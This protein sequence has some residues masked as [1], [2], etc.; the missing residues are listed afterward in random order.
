[1]SRVDEVFKCLIYH[2]ELAEGNKNILMHG[3]YMKG[4]H[5]ERQINGRTSL[6][7]KSR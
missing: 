5:F 1:M 4:K 3:R 6:Q 7:A 2:A